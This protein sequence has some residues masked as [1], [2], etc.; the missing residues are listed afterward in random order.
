MTHHPLDRRGFLTA[1]GAA[2]FLAATHG[3]EAWA[4]AKAGPETAKPASAAPHRL[5]SLDLVTEASFEE[6]Q[7]FYGGLLGLSTEARDDVLTIRGGLT[8][9]TFRKAE[10]PFLAPFYHFAFNIPENKLLAAR[11]WQLERTPLVPP[12]ENLRDPSFPADVVHFRTWDAHSVFFWDP[13]GN[14]VEYIARH[15]LDNAA[16]GPFTTQDIL[17]ASEIAF[18]SN[19]VEATVQT[20]RQALALPQYF[21]GSDQFRALGDEHGL[22][23]VFKKGR[24][25]GFETG[26]PIPI[27]PVH[28]RI[29][30]GPSPDFE[31]EGYPFRVSG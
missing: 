20:F 10:A 4:D 3:P 16:P 14:F 27:A 18:V 21:G 2:V 26:R 31:A 1:T 8:R 13:A 25:M 29:H 11:A 12:G 15:T 30:G 24:L 19:D 5:L 17:Y 22:L 7:E 28:A 9:I 23:L 6:M